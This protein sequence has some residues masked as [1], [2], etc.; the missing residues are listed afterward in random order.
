MNEEHVLSDSLFEKAQYEISFG[1]EWMAYDTVPYVLDKGEVYFFKN[2]NEAIE[3]AD[4]NISEYDDY[5]IINVH[6]I[7]DFLLQIHTEDLRKI[8]QSDIQTKM[9][10][11]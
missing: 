9:Y 6:S 8:S 10:Q 11:S 1:K 3:F 2:T 4:N 5:R 7:Q